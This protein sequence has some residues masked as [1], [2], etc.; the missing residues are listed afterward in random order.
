MTPATR[1]QHRRS[2]PRSAAARRLAAGALAALA[3]AAPAAG[4]TQDG[5]AALQELIQEWSE[6]RGARHPLPL[7]EGVDERYA[8]RLESVSVERYEQERRELEQIA[9]R[10][11]RIDRAALPAPERVDAELLALLLRD[12]IAELSF[13]SY[14]MPLGSRSGFHFAF[15]SLPETGTFRSVQEYDGYVAKLQSFFEHTLG[16]IELLRAGIAAGML[17]PRVILEGYDDTARRHV[18]ANVLDSEFY[19][20]LR[21][22]PD[23]LPAADRERILRDGTAAIRDSVI[24]AYRAFADFLAREYIPAGRGSIAASDLPDG[25]AFYRHRIR[26]YTTLELT[27]EQVHAMGLERVDELRAAMEAIRAEVGF[28]GTWEEFLAFLRE[29]PRFYVSTPRRYLEAVSYAAKLMEGHLPELFGRLPRTPYGIRAMPAHVAPRQSAGYYD[30]GAADGSRAGW[31]NINTSQLDS[32]PLWVVRPLAL[33][34]GVPG[35]HL[36]IMLALE[37]DRLSEF[38]RRNA[39]TVFVEGWGLY[40]ERL[41]TEVGLYADP[42]DRFGMYSYQ[43]WRAC[44]LVVDTGM[45]ALGWSRDRAIAFMADNTGMAVGPV[46]AEIDRHITEPGQGLA[47]TTGEI[48]ISALRRRA[49]ER[50]GEA[51]DLRAFHDALLEGG[52][53][54]LSILR[55]RMQAWIDAQAERSPRTGGTT[56]G[57][58]GTPVR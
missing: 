6:V 32:R 25:E 57:T 31:V 16:Q 56:A 1:R 11:A 8:D 45:H 43:I 29:D 26:R 7:P 5:P 13:R 10:L 52:A 30:R 33:H 55:R 28:A 18:V 24:P 54:P 51:F 44:R 20:P 46:T 41:G 42:Y 36:Q 38:R 34:E 14:L 48:E 23:T 21:R 4:R 19:A 49:E 40:A 35:H 15:A 27:P 12:R 2:E 47:Y 53:L 22:I 50:L 58:A 3:L 39:A 37:N 17:L 9:G